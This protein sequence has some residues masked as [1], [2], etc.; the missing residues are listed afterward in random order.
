[1]YSITHRIKYKL[2]RIYNSLLSIFKANLVYYN[3]QYI[4]GVMMNKLIQRPI[5]RSVI[6]DDYSYKKIVIIY[7]KRHFNP[8]FSDKSD[9][10][11]SASNLA[12]NIYYTMIDLTKMMG[13]KIY[14]VDQHEPIKYIGDVDII[15]GILSNS[16]LKY[17]K[18]YP[19]S[20]KILFLVNSHPLWRLREL[21]KESI[22][23][24]KIFPLS[25]FISPFIFIFLKKY[26]S[27]YI[28]IGNEFVRN[29]FVEYGIEKSD[30]ILLNSGVNSELL[31]PGINTK[32]E[33]RIRILY[34]ASILGIRKGL[35][36]VLKAWDI[37]EKMYELDIELI[38]IGQADKFKVEL[39]IFIKTHKKVKFMGW[40]DSSTESYRNLL[41][42]SDIIINPSIEEGQVGCV[43]EAMATGA[44]PIITN[45]CGIP[46]THNNEGL[47]IKN[48][49]DTNELVEKIKFLVENIEIREKMSKATLK[50]IKAN[51][52]WDLFNNTIRKIVCDIPL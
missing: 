32:A 5:N 44:V 4:L 23:L 11:Y 3:T 38:I 25:E 35:F 37:L 33:K 12:R 1:M 41:Q 45:N 15:I 52:S 30:I 24:G 19:N 47:I 46:I 21:V 26:V 29:T 40:I 49:K 13:G 51:H 50:Y 18:I 39:D 20:E 43:L 28:L 31:K 48:Y 10:Q 2:N 22:S 6:K 7:S 14:Y 34:P 42:S 36:R 16:F 17:S 8:D 9:L 27:K